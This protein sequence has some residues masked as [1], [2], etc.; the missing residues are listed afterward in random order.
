MKKT[1]FS[2]L[3]FIIVNMLLSQTSETVEMADA[4]RENGK[5]YNVVAVL[6]AVFLG[7]TVYLFYIDRKV[8]KLEDKLKGK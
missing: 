7:I 4:L 2:I 6:S 1:F 5:I 8:K 3:G